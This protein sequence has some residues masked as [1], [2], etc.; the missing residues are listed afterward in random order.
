MLK[1]FSK[2]NYSKKCFFYAEKADNKIVPTEFFILTQKKR[3]VL[4]VMS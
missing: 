1:G 3:L 2:I 4:N